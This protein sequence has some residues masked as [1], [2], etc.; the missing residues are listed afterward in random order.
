MDKKDKLPRFSLVTRIQGLLE[1]WVRNGCFGHNS[2]LEALRMCWRV[3]YR[4]K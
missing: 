2:L 1:F 4:E 3:V